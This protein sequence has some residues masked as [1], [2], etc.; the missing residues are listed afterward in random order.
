MAEEKKKSRSARELTEEEQIR[1]QEWVKNKA[2]GGPVCSVCGSTSWH[3]H[4]D[5]LELR[6]FFGGNVVFGGII[7][8]TVMLVCANCANTLLINAIGSGIVLRESLGPKPEAK[9]ADG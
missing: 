7:I 9:K 6:P 8:P 5:V 1:L 2:R 4:R 3:A